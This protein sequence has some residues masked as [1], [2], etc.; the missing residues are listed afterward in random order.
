MSYFQRSSGSAPKRFQMAHGLLLLVWAAGFGVASAQTPPTIR[1]DPTNQTVLV[2]GTAVFSVTAGGTG[3]FRYQWY[4]N[5]ALCNLL[6]NV[7]GNGQGGI[8]GDGGLATA[9]ELDP[10][11]SIALDEFGDLFIADPGQG[12]VRQVYPDGIITTAVGDGYLYGSPSPNG[13]LYPPWAVAVDSSGNLFIG[14]GVRVLKVGVNGIVTTVAGNGSS[15]YSGDGGPATSAELDEPFRL[16]VDKWGNLFINDFYNFRVRKVDTNGIITTVAGNPAGTGGDW[17]PATN[18]CLVYPGG[19]AV[20]GSGNLF[21]AD[22]LNGRIRR[23]DTNGIITTVAG[24]GIEAYGGDGGPATAAGLKAPQGVAVDDSGNLLIADTGDNRIRRVDTNGI[25]TTVAGNGVAAYCGDGGPATAAGLNQPV[26]VAV[27]HFGNLFI[28]D[29]GNN[30]VRA[31]TPIGPVLTWSNVT[32]AGAGNYWVVVSSAYGSATSAV[33]SL[34][35]ALPALSASI[36]PAT[37]T[38]P[39]AA[40]QFQFTGTAGSNYVLQS[41]TDLSGLPTWVPVVTNKAGANGIWTFTYTNISVSRAQ[42]FR[43]AAQ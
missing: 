28:A 20:D 27:D 5:G 40:V 37:T 1:Q 34:T 23:V 31:T 21:I 14:S 39:T 33:A 36:L 2:G 22:D 24:N 41:T 30:R 17:G 7:A 19:L 13:Y 11:D 26:G 8:S 43:L 3:P 4:F 29:S 6:T 32:P 38:S 9:A 15:G 10:P 42:F 12:R 35:V 16:A 18:V 25:I